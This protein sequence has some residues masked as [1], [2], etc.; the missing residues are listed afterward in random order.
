MEATELRAALEAILF[1]SNEPVKVDDLVEAF[2]EEGREAVVAQLD[3]IRKTLDANIG[4][5]MLE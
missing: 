1:I 2:A 4:G 3:E 5:F